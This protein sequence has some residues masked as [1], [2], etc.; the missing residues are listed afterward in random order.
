MERVPQPSGHRLTVRR[1][2]AGRI[3]RGGQTAQ[4]PISVELPHTIRRTDHIGRIPRIGAVRRDIGE[5]DHPTFC[6]VSGGR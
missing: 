4:R 2:F 3:L 1:R 6:D 5:G